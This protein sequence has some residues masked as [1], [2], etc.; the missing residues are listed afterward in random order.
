MPS[1]ANNVG[2]SGGGSRASITPAARHGRL[3]SRRPLAS[4]TAEMPVG[5]AR[6]AIAKEGRRL[7]NATITF[8]QNN[9]VLQMTRIEG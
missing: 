1:R 7:L 2:G 4:I 9:M 5:V 8:A 6:Y 3:W